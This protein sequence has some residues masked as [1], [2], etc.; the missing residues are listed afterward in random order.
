VDGDRQADEEDG[1]SSSG[2]D[3]YPPFEHRSGNDALDRLHDLL[4]RREQRASRM[5]LPTLA[6]SELPVFY[7]VIADLKQSAKVSID[8]RHKWE[9][10]ATRTPPDLRYSD[11]F[12]KDLLQVIN[13]LDAAGEALLEVGSESDVQRTMP[14]LYFM[15]NRYLRAYIGEFIRREA[16]T[17]WA[18]AG[19]P[20]KALADIH[21]RER[22]PKRPISE[23]E[24]ERESRRVLQMAKANFYASATDNKRNNSRSNKRN[25]ANPRH[26]SQQRGASSSSSSSTARG[27]AHQHSTTSNAS[28]SGSSAPSAGHQN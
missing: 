19:Q 26:G 21:A 5:A 10:V 2:G 6:P 17:A 12:L 22:D 27:S 16:A 1:N 11:K 23:A 25:N 15:S 14:W 3:V 7:Q 18:Q 28:G 24:A 9:Y 4:P 8:E 20:M 13:T